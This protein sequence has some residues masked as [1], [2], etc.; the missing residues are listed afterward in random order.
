MTFREK[1][2][3]TPTGADLTRNKVAVSASVIGAGLVSVLLQF[4]M[5]GKYASLMGNLSHQK[6][7]GYEVAI[8]PARNLF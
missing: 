8:V 6:G 1:V 5:L 4:L 7:N 2:T 3:T